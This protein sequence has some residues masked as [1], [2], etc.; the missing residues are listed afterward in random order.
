[1]K[2]KNQAKA[3]WIFGIYLVATCALLFLGYG[4]QKPA[5]TRQEF[6]FT[7]T[8][9]FQGKTETI[10]DIY[11]GEYSPHE[12]YLGDRSIAWYGYVEDRNRLE[13]DFYRIGESEGN[14]FSINLN[15]LPGYL[16][17][18]PSYADSSF[19]P[20][21][22]CHSSDGVNDTRI[23]DPAELEQ[24][25]LSIVSWDYPDPIENSFSFGGLSL[26]SEAAILTTILAVCACIACIILIKKDK[27][28]TCS[29][30]DKISVVLNFLN[31]LILFPFILVVG[32]FIEIVADTTFLYQVLYL[33]PA[34]TAL[35]IAL[36]VT[37]RR[38][39]RKHISF[40]IQFVGPIVFALSL[41][42][43]DI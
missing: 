35:G 13:S 36:S 16:M 15:I 12:K 31:G 9:T 2:K 41:L 32:I 39:G 29:A 3:L 6:P 27:R 38:M 28:L 7:I 8:Y 33:S 17:G 30:L 11:V 25:G 1:M 34:V 5:V 40:W 37:L 43:E 21:G 42:L 10:S 23:T 19:S 14:F 18:D 26:S 4:V 22:V 20:T 24:L